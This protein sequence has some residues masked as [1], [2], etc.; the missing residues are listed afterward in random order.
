MYK[1]KRSGSGANRTAYHFTLLIN[2]T[3]MFISQLL[4]D[5]Q[6][7]HQNI[8]MSQM[9]L[10]NMDTQRNTRSHSHRRVR[11][12]H[13]GNSLFKLVGL[14]VMVSDNLYRWALRSAERLE[15]CEY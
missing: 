8:N 4:D 13:N 15:S 2:Y 7:R 5:L 10:D 9:V 11:R 12:S 3:L 6:Y 1:Q 14:S